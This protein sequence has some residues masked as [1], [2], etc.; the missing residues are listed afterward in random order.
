VTDELTETLDLESTWVEVDGRRLHARRKVDLAPP[1]RPHLVLVHGVAVSSRNMSPTAEAF[2][3]HVPV[4]SP[5]LPG[6]G[7]SDHADHV[8][9][10]RE[11]ADALVGWMDASG[12]DTACLLGNSFG[13]QIAAEVAARHPER[14]ERLVLQGPTTDP[15]A[16]SYSR[17]IVRWIR[18]GKLEGATQ[19]DVTLQ[20]WTDAGLKVLLGTFRHCVRHRI[21]DVLPR[22]EAPTL[23]VRGEG[24]PIV[25]QR[26]AEEV[27]ALLADGRL[28]VLPDVSHTITNTRPYEL[29]STALPFLLGGEP[30]PRP[31]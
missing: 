22:I 21:E 28:V 10:T 16:R 12:L 31:A 27:T 6:H 25:P 17:Q 7:R 24:D 18:N 1:G 15:Q 8:L 13:C 26:W 20:E 29:M 23:V 9:S 14:V 4:H 19:S 30:G 5:D 3:T 11:L 2:A